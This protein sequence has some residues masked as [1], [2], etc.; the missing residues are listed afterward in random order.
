MRGNL[1]H[2]EG[3]GTRGAQ[4]ACGKEVKVSE[5][6]RGSFLV[7]ICTDQVGS[8]GTASLASRRCTDEAL[9]ALFTAFS[10][11]RHS[12][13]SQARPRA[14]LKFPLFQS[15]LAQRS[16]EDEVLRGAQ[17]APQFDVIL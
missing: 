2:G 14:H 17:L 7:S 9:Q 6:Q 11:P 1:L 8:R 12:W 13:P 4:D 5:T 16:G 3:M 15:V 10:Q